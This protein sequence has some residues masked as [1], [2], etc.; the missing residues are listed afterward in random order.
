[1]SGGSVNS[2]SNTSS[3]GLGAQL[4]ATPAPDGRKVSA[5]EASKWAS[6]N[7]VPVSVEV[8]ALSGENVEE[9]FNRL[10]RII[11]TKIKLV[12]IDPDD[13]MS[14]IQYGDGGWIGD[15]DGASVKSG[16]SADS[17]GMRK[18]RKVKRGWGIGRGT[19]RG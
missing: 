18:R 16:M 1:V 17:S 11:L 9:I 12:E 4:R 6:S 19:R 5:E 7:N 8:S 3:L 15:G 14:G 10:A 2:T 13:P